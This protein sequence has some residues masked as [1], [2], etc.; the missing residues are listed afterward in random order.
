MQFSIIYIEKMK[1]AV[2][3]QK[4]KTMDKFVITRSTIYSWNLISDSGDR[5]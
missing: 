5:K 1:D 2:E 3:R 4:K